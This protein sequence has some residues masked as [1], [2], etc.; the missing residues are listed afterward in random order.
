MEDDFWNCID[1]LGD[2]STMT[3]LDNR[4]GSTSA[5]ILE[6][7]VRSSIPKNTVMKEKWAVKLFQDLHQVWKVRMDDNVLKIYDDIDFMTV[8]DMNYVMQY[9]IADV[10]KK[11]GSKFPPRTLKEIVSMLQHYCNHNLKRPWSF[12]K[13]TEF[14]DLRRVLD[15]EM[16]L[17]ARE[18]NA[19]PARRSMTISFDDEEQLWRSG[20]L[21][22]SNPRQLVNTLIYLLGTHCALRAAYEH[23]ALNFGE[24]SQLK[25]EIVDE[26]EVLQYTECVSKAKNFGLKQ[27]R[28]DHK[29]STVHK[30]KKHPERCP[31]ELYKKYVK[32]RED[33]ENE[34]FYLTPMNSVTKNVW[35]KNQAF[36]IHSIQKV[37]ASLMQSIGKAGYFTKTSNRRIAKTRFT[38]AGIPREISKQKT[39]HI[40]MA[41]EV[42]I[43][44]DVMGKNRSLAI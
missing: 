34:S 2:D 7:H 4:F 32:Y 27:S 33:I 18:G 29:Q 22:S 16:K 30:N 3:T 43:Q 42:Y 38:L 13:D 41:D 15:A 23:R 20:A 36:G 24:R 35:C 14:T 40:S 1:D 39:G 28:M 11:D 6:E 25:I 44:K 10:R 31:V 9:F 17:S 8:S 26:E 12:F 19:R 21:G 5:A 37:T